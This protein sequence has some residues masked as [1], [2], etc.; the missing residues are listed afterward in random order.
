VCRKRLI[1]RRGGENP[2][3]AGALLVICDR[4]ARALPNSNQ[5]LDGGIFANRQ[6]QFF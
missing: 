2:C 1:A 3:L 6:Q 4:I 5:A